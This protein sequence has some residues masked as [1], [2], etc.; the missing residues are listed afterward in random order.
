MKSHEHYAKAQ[1]LLALQGNEMQTE[2][3]ERKANVHAALA[4]TALLA[5]YGLAAGEMNESDGNDWKRALGGYDLDTP[6]TRDDR[7]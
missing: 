3:R 1:D 5:E 6:D 7:V 2:R 4:H